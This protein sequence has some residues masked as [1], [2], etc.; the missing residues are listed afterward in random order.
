[1]SCEIDCRRLV[2]VPETGLC[3]GETLPPAIGH[4]PLRNRVRDVLIPARIIRK[5][6]EHMAE[7]IHTDFAASGRITIV[8]VLKG[9]FVFASD[10]IRAIMRHG[11]LEVKVDFYEAR[12]YGEEIKQKG[13]THRTVHILR[14]PQ[15]RTD[16]DLILVD[17]IADTVQTITALKEDAIGTLG[18]PESR[19]HL[20]F[21]LDKVLRQPTPAVARLKRDLNPAYVGFR[22]PD[23]WVA[24]YGIDAG[25]DFRGL[26]DVIAVREACYR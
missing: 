9:A 4:H 11:G 25:E 18:F 19:I 24:G 21:L 6:V 8:A 23:L 20:C 16:V 13:E 5:R 1:M 12:T 17:D 2:E 22:V 3:N 10:L 15:A 14:R 26:P 7:Q